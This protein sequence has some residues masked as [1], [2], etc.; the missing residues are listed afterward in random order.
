MG[1]NGKYRLNSRY[2]QRGNTIPDVELVYNGNTLQ[3]INKFNFLSCTLASNGKFSVTQKNPAGKGLKVVFSLNTLFATVPLN[4]S[5]KLKL[6]DHMV[7]PMLMYSSETWGFHK[8]H[9]IETSSFKVFK[10]NIICKFENH[11]HNSVR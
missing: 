9:D 7:L 6:F 3:V 5:E 2:G 1:S 4:I 10:A 8:A 11:K